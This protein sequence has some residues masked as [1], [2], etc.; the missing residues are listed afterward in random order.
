[1]MPSVSCWTLGAPP[2]RHRVDT[3]AMQ[4][5][6]QE[7]NQE[8]EWSA[9]PDRGRGWQWSLRSSEWPGCPAVC[10]DGGRRERGEEQS[11]LIGDCVR[12]YFET[13]SA[14]G[15]AMLIQPCPADD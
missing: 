12:C 13:S 2:G 3:L 15:L 4:A 10:E 1:M 7:D 9:R 14:Q 11:K 6:G 5:A 8:A